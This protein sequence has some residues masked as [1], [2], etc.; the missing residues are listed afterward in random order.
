LAALTTSLI[1]WASL[2]KPINLLALELSV[3][4]YPH[5]PIMVAADLGYTALMIF[6]IN[7]EFVRQAAD[8]YAVA[9]FRTLDQPNR[10]GAVVAE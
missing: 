8:E 10:S 1:W 7:A 3:E 5:L 9:L 2:G 6:M 4:T